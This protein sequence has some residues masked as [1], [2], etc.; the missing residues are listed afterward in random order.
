MAAETAS[1]GF[2]ESPWGNHPRLQILTVEELLDGK[3]VDM[4]LV[5]QTNVTAKRA[6]RVKKVEN[7]QKTFDDGDDE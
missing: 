2:Y 3:K 6:R 7:R 1:A 5:Q 4:P